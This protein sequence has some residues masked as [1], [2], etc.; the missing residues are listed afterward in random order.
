MRLAGSGRQELLKNL[1]FDAGGRKSLSKNV[2]IMTYGTKNEVFVVIF[3]REAV[4]S[5]AKLES[6]RSFW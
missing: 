2:F 1:F 6:S 3:L 4:K 5:M